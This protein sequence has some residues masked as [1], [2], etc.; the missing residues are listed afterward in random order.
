[1]RLNL[2][3]GRDYREG[4]VN[5]DHPDATTHKDVD[6]DFDGGL[7]VRVV[8]ALAD[9]FDHAEGSHVLEHLHEPLRFMQNLWRFANPGATARFLLPY[10]SSD[11]AWEDPTHVRP[12]FLNSFGFF[13]QPFYWRA[14]YG[15]KGDWQPKL[16]VL[17]LDGV[18]E[19]PD[20]RLMLLI[21][22]QRNV[23]AEMEVVLEAVKPAR[24]PE[25]ELQERPRLQIN[26]RS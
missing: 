20:D 15:Y 7:N 24:A 22:S 17:H 23:V 3:C 25:R 12:Y 5:V 8:D 2:G 19:L 6:W 21:N 13:S 14:D 11:D 10:G 1:M 4:W 26:L 18:P 9:G 16:I